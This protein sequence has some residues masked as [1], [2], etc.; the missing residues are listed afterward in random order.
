MAV[1]GAGP[2]TFVSE[3]TSP[4]TQ[5]Q[6]PLFYISFGA[7]GINAAAWPEW[8]SLTA[9]HTLIGN[10]LTAMANRNLLTPPPS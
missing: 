1:I 10:I 3:N 9:D 8:G 6:I 5:Y 2:V 7:T 4:G